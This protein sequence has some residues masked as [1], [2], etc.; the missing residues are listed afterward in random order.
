M[1]SDKVKKAIESRQLR[2]EIGVGML[3]DVMITDS[4][5]KIAALLKSSK[6]DDFFVRL[7]ELKK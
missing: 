5:R 7:G 2:G 4:W 3:P 1:S 6:G